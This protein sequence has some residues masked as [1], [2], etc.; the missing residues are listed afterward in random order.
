MDESAV[1][2]ESAPVIRE[3]GGDRSAVTG[4]TRVLSDWLIVRVTR[5]SGRGL[6]G[7]H[8]RLVEGAKRQ[9]TPNEIALNILLA[10]FTII[11]LVVCATLLPYSLYQR[12]GRR[13]G[14]A[15]SPSPCWSPCWSA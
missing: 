15:R 12:A 14:H 2:G 6:P 13:P 10:G 3:A 1:T 5:R 11:F 4:G 7:P 8:D 9:K